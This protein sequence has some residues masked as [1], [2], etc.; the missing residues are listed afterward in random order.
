MSFRTLSWKLAT[1]IQRWQWS[2]SGVALISRSR[3]QWLPWCQVG[4]QTTISVYGTVV[5]GPSTRTEPSTRFFSPPAGAQPNQPPDR[6]VY[7]SSGTLSHQQ[8]LGMHTLPPRLGTLSRCPQK[9]GLSC[10]ERILLLL[11]K[12][13]TFRSGLPQTLRHPAHDCRRA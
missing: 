11:W 7:P 6:S 8:P 9:E 3:M 10:P 4:Q 13:Q 2:N 1:L 12:A 5:P